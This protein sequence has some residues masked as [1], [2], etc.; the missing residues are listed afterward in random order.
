ML[1]VWIMS[2]CWSSAVADRSTNSIFTNLE[3]IITSWKHSDFF[4]GA[5]KVFFIQIYLEQQRF[6]N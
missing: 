5:L 6:I 3:G 4:L 2:S 1:Y